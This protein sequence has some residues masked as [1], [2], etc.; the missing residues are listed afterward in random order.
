MNEINENVH[1]AL[2]FDSVA[3]A[4]ADASNDGIILLDVEHEVAFVNQKLQLWMH[5]MGIDTDSW[6]LKK[7]KNCYNDV[8]QVVRDT[9]LLES[10]FESVEGKE[11]LISETL[12]IELNDELYRYF[13]LFTS[14][15]YHKKEGYLGRIWIFDNR[16]KQKK[17]ENAKTEFISIA[18]HQLR[19]PMTAVR[20]YLSMLA[21]GDVDGIEGEALEYVEEALEGA[22]RLVELVEDLLNLSRLEMGTTRIEKKKV[23][24]KEVVRGIVKLHSNLIEE[25]S[26]DFQIYFDLGKE[27][28][29]LD[30]KL[31]SH[32]VG[33]ILDN[34][35]KYTPEFG[36]VT[37]KITTTNNEKNKHSLLVE[38][39][40]SGVGI[41][42][43]EKDQVFD[44]FF[45]AENVKNS[46]FNGS[47]IGLY[48][49]K[50]L[51]NTMKGKIWLE[52]EEGKG[53]TF[54]CEIPSNKE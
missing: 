11:N 51:V 38:I 4:V 28:F 39:E 45:R 15:V 42:D 26:I 14:P 22:D 18:S 49:V 52:S 27:E 8:L 40:D 25:K 32:I 5:R 2:L 30:E 36:Q 53:T 19:T 10:L 9:T 21:A 16:T 37:M 23:N 34:S 47:G 24:L 13:N 44:K 1:E 7:D 33:N 3:H 41:P 29:F 43:A 46:S 20:G 31:F 6:L 54:Y 48:Y 17:I 12:D 35:I 50:Q